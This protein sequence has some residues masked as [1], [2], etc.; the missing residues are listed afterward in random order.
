MTSKKTVRIRWRR[1]ATFLIA[2]YLVY[3]SGVSIHHMWAISQQ[4]RALNQKIAAVQAQNRVLT[5]DVR[6][7][8]NPRK[9]REMLTGQAPLPSI[10]P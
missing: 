8:H 1:I 4:E 9:L 3:W 6:T 10:T 5:Q 7:L 2:A